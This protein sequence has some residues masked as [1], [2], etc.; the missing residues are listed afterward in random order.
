M[1]KKPMNNLKKRGASK[2]LIVIIHGFTGSPEKMKYVQKI[3]EDYDLDADIYTPRLPYHRIFSITSPILI[4]KKL[5]KSID[6]FWEAKTKTNSEGY[7][8]II[9]IG[10]STGGL[11]VRKTFI[12]ACGE[13]PEAPFENEISNKKIRVWSNKVDKIILLA[14]INRGWGITKHLSFKHSFLFQLGFGLA[15]IFKPFFAFTIMGFRRGAPFVTELRAQWLFLQRNNESKK[16]QIKIPTTIQL[17]GSIDD[18]VPPEDNIDLI[19]GSDFIYLDVPK[20]NHFSILKMDNSIDGKNRAEIFKLALMEDEKELTEIHETPA[21]LNNLVLPQPDVTDVI[22]VMHGIRDEGYWTHKVARRIKTRA[23]DQ[24]PDK[25]FATETSSYGYFPILSFL[26]TTRREKKVHWLM[27]EYIEALA[28]Y[29]NAKFSYVG[30]SNGTY[31]LAKAFQEYECCRFKNVVFASSVVRTDYD[32]DNILKKGKVENVLNFVATNDKVVAWAPYAFERLRL[33]I[34][35]LGGAG[36]VGFKS[37]GIHQ[38]KYVKGG[39]S[40]PIGEESW[41]TIADFIIMGSPQTTNP[42]ILSDQQ[43]LIFKRLS[44]LGQFGFFI[45]LA[46]AVVSTIGTL[47]WV[48]IKPDPQKDG[49]DLW[50][51]TMEMDLVGIWN[52]IRPEDGNSLT[53]LILFLVIYLS[54]VLRFLKKF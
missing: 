50:T 43:P 4:V 52:F 23:K 44:L 32:W 22:F 37:N 19:S 39:H 20:S 7:E 15:T 25:K 21:D 30:H 6:D 28:Y 8:R 18:L 51:L 3:V 47:L 45:L 33:R 38:I 34:L 40:A 31:L 24:F 42:E 41:D 12:L 13:Q 17:L 2:S 9:L 53:L 1:V 29:P 27:E 11:I 26:F 35:N 14:A 54:L 16:N 36:H 49:K 10:A 46:I 48:L 5:I